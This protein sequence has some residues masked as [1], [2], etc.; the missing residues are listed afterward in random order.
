MAIVIGIAVVFAWRH[1]RQGRADLRG[2]STAGAVLFGCSLVGWVCSTSHVPD[3]FAELISFSW[4][5][6]AA[7]F[8]GG[9][10]WALYV[11]LE[12][13]VRRRWPQSMI[14]WSR[15]LGGGVRRADTVRRDRLGAA[16]SHGHVTLG[17]G[18]AYDGGLA[19]RADRVGQVKRI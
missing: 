17:R 7:A 6:S 1:V 19:G 5:V 15:L 18:R 13:H 3:A 9:G 4:A 2:A 16:G 12:P 10:F 14:S 8:S 11:A